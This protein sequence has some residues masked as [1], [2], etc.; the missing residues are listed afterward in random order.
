MDVL[1]PCMAVH[2]VCAGCLKKPEDG[3]LEL[4]LQ[5]TVSCQMSL[6]IAKCSQLLTSSAALCFI[7]F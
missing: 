3:P 4:E 7:Y 5:V 6:N 2:H 1:T